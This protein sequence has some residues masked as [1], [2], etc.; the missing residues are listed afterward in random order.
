MYGR[1]FGLKRFEIHDGD[2]IRSTLFLKGCPL[3]CKW[4]HNPEGMQYK[5]CLGYV[6]AKCI[7][8]GECVAVCPNGA[9]SIGIK[10]DNVPYHIFKRDKCLGCGLCEKV[11]LGRAL[12]LY[13]R[14]VSCEEILP[15][16]LEDRD[17]YF[18]SGGGVTLSGGEPAMQAEFS[19]EILKS[20]K[21]F[22]IH[23][24]IDTCGYAPLNAYEKMLPYTDLVLYDLKAAS[25][26]VHEICTGKSNKMILDNLSW[27]DKANI[28]IDIRIPLIP[29]WNDNE[30]EP[31]TKILLGIKNLRKTKVL[32]YHSFGI[33]KYSALEMEYPIPNTQEPERE[34]VIKAVKTLRTHGINATDE[35]G[36][37]YT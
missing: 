27:I 16:L 7:N 18:A 32:P 36:E 2:G 26:S 8:C 21:S 37:T 31:M 3:A 6:E 30:L 33:A 5:A 25:S 35:T 11:C 23:T 29:G 19:S 20:L 15:R 28:P 9:Q 13:G 22:G 4:C 12:T 1:I 17:F 10:N 24:A 14:D 34:T